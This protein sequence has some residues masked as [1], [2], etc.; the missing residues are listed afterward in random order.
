MKKI[1]HI[2]IAVKNIDEAN[3]LFCR[4]LGT[5]NFQTETVDS[6]GVITSC[7]NI[8]ESKIELVAALD[9]TSTIAKFI[10]NRKQGVHHIA[11]S[12]SDINLEIQRLKKEGISLL[13]DIPKKGANNKLIC[14]LDPRETNGVLIEICQKAV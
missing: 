7:F 8:G 1:D 11:L 10:R 14:F 9:S 3:K 2:G 13:N 6:E 12:V 4:I 5:N